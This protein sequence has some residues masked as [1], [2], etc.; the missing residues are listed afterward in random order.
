MLIVS[1]LIQGLI[2]TSYKGALEVNSFD[3]GED[4]PSFPTLALAKTATLPITNS[5]FYIPGP[6]NRAICTTVSLQIP[7]PATYCLKTGTCPT[8]AAVSFW[9]NMPVVKDWAKAGNVT[10]G[11]FGVLDIKYGI[12]DDIRGCNQTK[13]A[14]IFIKAPCFQFTCVWLTMIHDTLLTEVWSHLVVTTTQSSTLSVYY[15]GQISPA[16][17]RERFSP[18]PTANDKFTTTAQAY[19]CIDELIYWNKH[20]TAAEVQVMYNAVAYNGKNISSFLSGVSAH[21]NLFI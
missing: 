7:L 19:G 18:A 13:K 17:K 1:F 9:L 12:V 5:S 3:N 16:I 2:P 8:G 20:L 6:V 11:K 4:Y 14:A 10:I 21:T 15:N